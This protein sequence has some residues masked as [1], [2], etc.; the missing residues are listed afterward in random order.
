MKDWRIYIALNPDE[1]RAILD[2]LVSTYP[3][4]RFSTV[5]WIQADGINGNPELLLDVAAE[6]EKSALAEAARVFQAARMYADLPHEEPRFTGYSIP[7][8]L[9]EPPDLAYWHKADLARDTGS[10]ADA[11]VAVQISCE[12]LARRTL[13]ALA[14]AQGMPWLSR[15]YKARPASLSDDVTQSLFNGLS[16]L[17]IQAEEWWQS[18]RDHA[19]RRNGILHRGAGVDLAGAEASIEAGK[20]F[21]TYV[22]GALPAV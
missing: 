12:V 4:D 17:E 1:E 11:V 2:A 21:R 22:R 9:G 5:T 18:Y 7:E 6:T 3:R 13:D 14:E 10:Y 8:E 19:Q 20:A 15:L 16:G